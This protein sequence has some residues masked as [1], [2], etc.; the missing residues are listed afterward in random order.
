MYLCHTVLYVLMYVTL[1]C[2]YLCH[3]VLYVRMSHCTY[4]LVTLYCMY[5]CMSHCTVCTYV[6]HTVLYV[7]VSHCSTYP[8]QLFCVFSLSQ[9]GPMPDPVPIDPKVLLV[10]QEPF[11]GLVLDGEN[12]YR[13]KGRMRPDDVRGSKVATVAVKQWW[14]KEYDHSLL[15][16]EDVG[17]FYSAEGYVIRWAFRATILRCLEGL[18]GV[19]QN[20]SRGNRPVT[21]HVGDPGA[22]PGLNKAIGGED[23]FLEDSAD[24]DDDG[25][26]KPP[27]TES[28]GTDRYVSVVL[29]HSSAVLHQ[30]VAWLYHLLLSWNVRACLSCVVVACCICTVYSLVSMCTYLQVS[31]VYVLC[32][33]DM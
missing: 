23:P 19:S 6:C 8:S 9:M 12:V 28:G 5:L 3:T 25:N 15:S 30:L 10:E 22:V 20:Q 1:Y 17:I 27:V 18:S 29:Y 16:E 7:P 24:E 11:K 13:G 14:I 33:C 26:K 21:W 4:V 2:M 32:T 31:V